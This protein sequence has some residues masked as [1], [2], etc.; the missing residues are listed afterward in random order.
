L[1]SIS[2]EVQLFVFNKIKKANDSRKIMLKTCCVFDLVSQKPVD[3]QII[4]RVAVVV[5]P[6][7]GTSIYRSNASALGFV[8]ARGMHA[9]SIGVL[10]DLGPLAWIS[11][12][13]I[14]T[15]KLKS[16]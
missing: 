15:L 9:L 14:K 8:L 2:S 6:S 7:V 1:F 11:K 3:H 12:L 16:S 5:V 13:R 4:V 10:C